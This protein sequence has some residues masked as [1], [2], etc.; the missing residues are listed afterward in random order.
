MEISVTI[1]D[2]GLM[3]QA[4]AAYKKASSDIQAIIDA[5]QLILKA[6]QVAQVFTGGAASAEIAA[7]QVLVNAMNEAKANLDELVNVLSQKLENYRA[8]DAQAQ[9]IASGAQQAVWQTV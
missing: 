8:A 9:Q 5:Y 6:L 4:I 2:F 3:E 1:V 7:I